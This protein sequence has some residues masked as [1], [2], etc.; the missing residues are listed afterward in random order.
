VGIH[1]T[2]EKEANIGSQ[3]ATAAQRFAS[4]VSSHMPPLLQREY[5]SLLVPPFLIHPRLGLEF[6]P[7]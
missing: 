3:K 5:V 1:G 2:R 4:R 6:H 7:A